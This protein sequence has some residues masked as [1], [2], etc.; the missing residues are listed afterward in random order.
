MV[1]A[2]DSG[3]NG[4]GLSLLFRG[5]SMVH[6][7][8]T[9]QKTTLYVTCIIFKLVQPRVA[10]L[11]CSHPQQALIPKLRDQD[12]NVVISVLAAIGEH[13]QVSS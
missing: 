9:L 4:P 2:L 5:L 10:K 6:S 3:S 7:T 11:N 8:V 1:S 12:P 13:A